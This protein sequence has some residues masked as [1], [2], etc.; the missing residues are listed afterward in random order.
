MSTAAVIQQL[1]ASGKPDAAGDLG[2]G[3]AL[4]DILGSAARGLPAVG[5]G[6]MR[7]ADALT[8]PFGAI[9]KP[10]LR[11][12]GR[13]G[14]EVSKS[15]GTQKLL[16]A[17]GLGI[18]TLGGAMASSMDKNVQ[19]QLSASNNPGGALKFSSHF[20]KSAAPGGF[21]KALG[22]GFRNE[23]PGAIASGIGKGVGTGL[24]DSLFSLGSTLGGKVL[25]STVTAPKREKIFYEAVKTDPVLRDS[26]RSNPAVLTQMKEAFA[27]MVR[28]APSLSLDINAV[29]SYLREAVIS[30]GGINYATIK[31]LADTEKVIHDRNTPRK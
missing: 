5:R 9:G 30:G 24:I 3:K 15:P 19:E 26:L 4:S 18:P 10:V 21:A 22:G 6:V 27:T 29:R 31:Q 11:N 20:I 17:A 2:R 1:H 13:L 12:L 25:E 16:I 28:F 23:L 7:A 8:A 14:G